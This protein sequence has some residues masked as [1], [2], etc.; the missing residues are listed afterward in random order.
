VAFLVLIYKGEIDPD[1]LREQLKIMERVDE[2]QEALEPASDVAEDKI[3][4]EVEQKGLPEKDFERELQGIASEEGGEERAAAL[5]N[6]TWLPSKYNSENEIIKDISKMMGVNYTDAL[7][8]IPSYPEEVIVNNRNLPDLV[9]DMRMMRR[10]VKGDNRD[11]MNKAISHLIT[12]YQEHIS[13]CLDS[14]YWVRP[15]KDAFKNMTVKEDTLKKLYHVKDG[16]TRSEIINILCKIWEANLERTGVDYGDEYHNITKEIKTNQSSFRK[17]LKNISHQSIRKSKKEAVQDCIVDIVCKSPGITSNQIHSRMPSKYH[18]ISSPQSISKMLKRVNATNVNGGYCILPSDIKKDLYSY[19]AGFIDSDGYITMD[20]KTSPRV[21]MIATGDRGRAFFEELSKE[22]HIGRL[23]LD[24]K[25][26][27]N[28]RSQHRLNFYSQD[29][30]STLL[31]KC[32]PHLRMK[33]KQAELLMEAI[34]IKKGYKK[35]EWCKPRLQEIFKLIKYENWKDARNKTEWEKYGIDPTVVVKYHDNSKMGLM[36]EMEMIT[37]TKAPTY[38]S[39]AIAEQI[40]KGWQE[41]NKEG[42]TA[43]ELKKAVEQ[44]FTN[45]KGQ[46]NEMATMWPVHVMNTVKGM[47]KFGLLEKSDKSTYKFAGE[48]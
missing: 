41:T 22:M 37:K 6:K 26:G 42:F 29:D 15:Y 25:V 8:Y 32:I 28:S 48:E 33:Q 31:E 5:L 20:S 2:Q 45:N 13:K 38:R 12:A 46:Y 36:D 47:V 30:I 11:K 9:K 34:R 16:D 44:S 7:K 17:I 27:E 10:Q 3:R 1:E 4:E 24:Q 19:I 23:H 35:E 39:K 21:G 43:D 18:K 14:I 40:I